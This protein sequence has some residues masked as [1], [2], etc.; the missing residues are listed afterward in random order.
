[1]PY[2]YLNK[3]AVGFNKLKIPV[4]CL[5]S[6]ITRN[7]PERLGWHAGP[8][9]KRR[10]SPSTVGNETVITIA[11]EKLLGYKAGERFDWHHTANGQINFIGD[12]SIGGGEA[13]CRIDG[14][15]LVAHWD[16]GDAPGDPSVAGVATFPGERLLFNIAKEDEGDTETGDLA[17]LTP[18]G[19]AALVA[20]LSS[21]SPVK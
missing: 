8:T 13:L 4:V 18:A 19:K 5:T 10:E 15:V 7:D 9:Y 17:T 2:H 20:A 12:G 21:L 16:P 3:R 6:Y 14:K 1:M 11:G